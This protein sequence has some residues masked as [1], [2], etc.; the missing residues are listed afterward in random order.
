MR[1]K[2]S[3]PKIELPSADAHWTIRNP[4]A[5][6]SQSMS[7]KT[8]YGI[9]ALTSRLGKARLKKSMRWPK[10]PA[11]RDQATWCVR[12]SAAAKESGLCAGNRAARGLV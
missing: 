5:N 8:I 6:V 4:E 9:C 12:P 2:A 7:R 10:R 1:V 3:S 11:W